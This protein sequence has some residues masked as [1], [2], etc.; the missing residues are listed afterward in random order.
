MVAVHACPS[1]SLPDSVN[2]CAGVMFDFE[3]IY[4]D[5]KMGILDD[6]SVE[7]E[8]INPPHMVRTTV[9]DG[10]ARYFGN[11]PV[12]VDPEAIK[13]WIYPSD[14]PIRDYQLNIV[15]ESLFQNTLVS[16]PT[17]LGKTLIAAVVMYNYY[18]W[19][20]TCKPSF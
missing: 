18:R 6:P 19:F 1:I 13:T 7:V 4:D 2:V 3:I 9:M 5:S 15:R 20:P 14:P 17:G 16:L 8:E 10:G 11:G 12:E